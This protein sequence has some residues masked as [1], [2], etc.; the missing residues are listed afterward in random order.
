MRLCV[1]MWTAVCLW[2]CVQYCMCVCL[3]VDVYVCLCARVFMC[4]YIAEN[5]G[6]R[7]NKYNF[8]EYNRAY[9]NGFKVSVW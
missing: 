1:C 3:R 4:V 6:N 7:T 9:L 8:C 2:L 5:W